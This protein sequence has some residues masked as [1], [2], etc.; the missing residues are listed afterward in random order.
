MSTAEPSQPTTSESIPTGAVARRRRRFERDADLNL[1]QFV[2]KH[3]G[4]YLLVLLPILWIAIFRYWPLYGVTMAFQ[5]FT[6]RQGYFGSPWVGLEHFIDLFENRVFMRAFW[7]TWIINAMRIVFGFPAP[8]ILALLINEI[9]RRGFQRTVQTVTYL[10]HFIGWVVLAGIFRSILAKDTGVLNNLFEVI[11]LMRVDFL[12]SN[13]TF[14]GVLVA[15]EIWRE[16]GFQ[17][18]IYFAAIAAINPELY[19]SAA[20]DGAGR[21]RRI[22][23]ITIPGIASTMIVLLILR[24]GNL[25]TVG[26]DQVYNMYNPLVYDTG[27]IIQTYILRMIQENP[28]WSRLAAAGLIRS[29]IGLVL[30]LVAN[31]VVRFFGREGIY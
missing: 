14:R 29:V 1:P 30:L 9:P 8:I 4:M 3:R 28:H 17:T 31:R 13:T 26:F 24:L 6:F 16:V 25:L 19:E 10:P 20:V 12:Q 21:F 5:Q 18:I 2:W 15:T 22:W 27:D 23:H 11:G 7:N